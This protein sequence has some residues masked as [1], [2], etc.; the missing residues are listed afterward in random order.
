LAPRV[1]RYM[2]PEVVVARPS[3]NLAHVRRLMLRHGVSRIVV[4]DQH[5][6]PV[7]VVT[8]TDLVNAVLGRFASRPLNAVTV[9]QV[10][11]HEPVTITP[12]KSVKSAAEVMLRNR[13]GGLPVVDE[14][15]ELAGIITRTD[16]ARAYADAYAGEYTVGDLAREPVVADRYH[17]IFHVS[18]LMQL[19][20]AGKVIVVDEEGRPVGVIAK[21]DLAFAS[22]P[23]EAAVARGK[24]RFRKARHPDPRGGDRVVALRSYLVPVAADIMTPDPVVAEEGLDA[25]EAAR[26]MVD[27]GIGVLPVVDGEGRLVGVVT[28]IELLKVI[29]GQRH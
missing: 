6:R 8:V 1:A 3:D 24:D 28:K 4:V 20:P 14:A 17:S 22:I 27:Y 7:G 9:D 26:M 21:R 2:T 29:A 11:T 15:G 25:A 5:R 19:D 10:M 13:I 16:L 18:R 23:L 12:R